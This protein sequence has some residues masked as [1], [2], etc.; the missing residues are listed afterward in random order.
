MSEIRT[1]HLT[2]YFFK[3]KQK[4]L[5]IKIKDSEIRYW[6][7]GHCKL[8]KP[9]KLHLFFTLS[10]MKLSFPDVSD[11]LLFLYAF[12]FLPKSVLS[13]HHTNTQH[14]GVLSSPNQIS[15]KWILNTKQYCCELKTAKA[16]CTMVHPIHF[17]SQES[18]FSN[19]SFSLNKVK[20]DKTQVFLKCLFN[21]KKKVDFQEQNKRL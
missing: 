4:S 17:I 19:D 10:R 6:F 2:S 3:K 8:S 12:L 18:L 14:L 13:H 7:G 11:E 21:K 16:T 1:F 20:T 9:S 5:L 15:S